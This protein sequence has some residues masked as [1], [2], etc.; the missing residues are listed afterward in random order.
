MIW[1][2]VT[3]TFSL[4]GESIRTNQLKIHTTGA[5]SSLTQ[6]NY[7]MWQKIG[8][9]KKT[10]GIQRSFYP[11]LLD[12]RSSGSDGNGPLTCKT[13]VVMFLPRYIGQEYFSNIALFADIL[14]HSQQ[15]NQESICNL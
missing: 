12:Y 2:A 11:R 3:H 6:L 10:P 1:S 7:R 4:P 9:K 14:S 5:T 8:K 13:M 15:A